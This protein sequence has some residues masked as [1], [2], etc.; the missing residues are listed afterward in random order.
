MAAAEAT[1]EVVAKTARKVVTMATEAIEAATET[2]IMIKM[3]SSKEVVTTSAVAITRAEAATVIITIKEVTRAREAAVIGAATVAHPEITG[4]A[5][6]MKHLATSKNRTASKD[7]AGTNNS[8]AAVLEAAINNTVSLSTKITGSS[9]TVTMRPFKLSRTTDSQCKRWR[10]LTRLAS[11]RP[12]MALS[13]NSIADKVA[14]KISSKISRGAVAAT[15]VATVTKGDL[16]AV[17]S[18]RRG[19][20]A[21]AT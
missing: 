16:R 1:E 21:S 6:T 13:N 9:A 17:T 10:T 15:E 11:S 3:A 7:V 14:I 8:A 20:S 2:T 4:A 19:A 5:K 12:L 18:L